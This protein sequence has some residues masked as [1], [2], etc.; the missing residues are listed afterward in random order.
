MTMGFSVSNAQVIDL[1]SG[2]NFGSLDFSQ[3][4]NATVQL[5]T[6]GTINV[7]GSGVVANGGEA[8]GHIRIT[9]PDTGIIEVKCVAQ[10]QLFDASATSIDIENIEISVN[11]G[12]PF[13]N[14]LPCGGIGAGDPVATTIDMDALPDPNVFVGGEISIS[15][16]ITLP[17][18]RVY[19]TTGGGVPITFSIV[20][21]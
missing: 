14:G 12:V 19:N 9:A 10:A 2:A 3:N 13:G 21:Q 17:T 6:N 4:Y 11:S 7:T 15:S 20:V 5:A 18:D 16:P 1:V 8:A